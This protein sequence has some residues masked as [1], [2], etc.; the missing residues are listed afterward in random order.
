MSADYAGK[1]IYI[2][3]YFAQLFRAYH[4]IRG[5]MSSPV[6]KEPTNATFGY[7]GML[8][9]VLREYKPDYLVVAMD[10]SGDCETFRSTIYPEYKANRE[11]PPLDFRPQATRCLQ[12]TSLMGIPIFGVETFEADDV[13]A[14]LVTRLRKEQP[15]LQIR[16]VSKD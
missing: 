3:D 6:T 12:L 10:K 11:P 14:T 8:L 4:A 13:I 15:D 5:G 7:V 9:K 16:I 1:T 2:I